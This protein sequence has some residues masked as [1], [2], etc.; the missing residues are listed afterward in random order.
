MAEKNPQ[1]SMDQLASMA[2]SP[3]GQALYS[4][5]LK[6]N[7]S[8]LQQA[9][10]LAQAGDMAAAGQILAPLLSDPTIR[11]QIDQLRNR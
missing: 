4:T 7:Q 3:A 2:S 1:F 9:M 11:Q 10:A 8:Q 5:L 6:T